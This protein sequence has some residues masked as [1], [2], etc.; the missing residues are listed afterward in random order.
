M[1]KEKALQRSS[2][3]YDHL[4]RELAS[5]AKEMGFALPGSVQSRFFECT[6]R[7]NCRCHEDPANRHGPYHY[8]TGTVQGRQT[9]VTVS[10]D[11]LA[12][13][14]EWIDNAR[15]LGRVIKQ[16]QNESLRTFALLTGKTVQKRRLV[17]GSK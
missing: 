14:Q 16:M 1:S 12:V 8:W 4:K 13:V 7:N 15:A 11:Q 3:R 10:E 17:T 2:A 9:S 5:L 6:R